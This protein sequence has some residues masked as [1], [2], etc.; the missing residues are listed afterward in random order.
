MPHAVGPGYPAV[1][2]ADPLLGPGPP[3]RD[4]VPTSGLGHTAAFARLAL[5]FTVIL[6]LGGRPHAYHA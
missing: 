2:T 3:G 4:V 1:V 6:V 5:P